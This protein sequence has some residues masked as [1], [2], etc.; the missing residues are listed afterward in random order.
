MSTVAGEA[1]GVPVTLDLGHPVAEPLDNLRSSLGFNLQ[2]DR[3]S[4]SPI[5]QLGANRFQ[6]IP[7]FFLLQIE[8]AVAGNSECSSG[9]DLISAIG[10]GDCECIAGRSIRQHAERVGEFAGWNRHYGR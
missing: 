3:I 5:V 8:V 2:A 6:Q 9:D 4:L 1:A 10:A 7:G